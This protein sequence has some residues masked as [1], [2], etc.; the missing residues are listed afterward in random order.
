MI[1]AGVW[2]GVGF[3][4]LKNCRT[5]IQK[6]WNRSG[7][8]VWKN[9]SGHLCYEVAAVWLINSAL[10]PSHVMPGRSVVTTSMQKRAVFPA[11][12]SREV[13]L[14]QMRTIGIHYII[15][16]THGRWNCSVWAAPAIPLLTRVRKEEHLIRCYKDVV[17]Q[18]RMSSLVIKPLQVPP[19]LLTTLEASMPVI[20]M[21][22][23]NACSAS[24]CVLSGPQ[25]QV[26][27]YRL[28]KQETLV[29]NF[30]LW[31]G[32]NG[33]AARIIIFRQ[34]QIWEWNFHGVMF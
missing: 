18:S 23:A 9:D 6:F 25:S 13:T 5:R 17:N 1:V 33:T 2:A 24:Y 4:N 16:R 3:S 15:Y 22:E 31:Y 21:C 7:V 28:L 26:S 8:G 20:L 32:N 10:Y 19:C 29:N 12:S 14:G 30:C 11:F 27:Q 34:V